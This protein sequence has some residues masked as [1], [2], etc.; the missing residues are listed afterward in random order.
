MRE[1]K[2]IIKRVIIGVL[3][4]I[5]L[6]T[7]KSVNAKAV[8]L[9]NW[10]SHILGLSANQR[11]LQ[12]SQSFSNT[13]SG[14]NQWSSNMT[15]GK[16]VDPGDKSYLVFHIAYSFN[17]GFYEQT[18]PSQYANAYYNYTSIPKNLIRV[19]INYNT[20]DSTNLNVDCFFQDSYLICPAMNS[21]MYINHITFQ[22]FNITAVNTSDNGRIF[23]KELQFYVYLQDIYYKAE[24]FAS[25]QVQVTTDLNTGQ[26]EV[27]NNLENINNTLSDNSSANNSDVTQALD[28]GNLPGG[29]A[30]SQIITL[31]LN[32]L[33]QLLSVLGLSCTDAVIPLP[34]INQNFTY[35]CIDNIFVDLGWDSQW[36][37]TGIIA[38]AIVLYK[39]LL[40]LYDRVNRILFLEDK[41]DLAKF[42]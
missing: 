5:I 25:Q 4:A 15:I 26:V 23:N 13:S 10:T 37:L 36:E 35:K 2:Y 7:I 33:N 21:G 18:V 30:I 11:I 3:I 29:G 32:L 12:G 9:T 38:G 1:I 39:Y 28:T 14:V 19:S 17:Y 42:Y 24:S 6:M 41:G 31:P 8:E 40:F 27:N 22:A 20:P 34:F 16:S